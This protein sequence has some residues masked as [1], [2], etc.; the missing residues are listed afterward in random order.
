MNAATVLN[1]PEQ[2]L[3]NTPSAALILMIMT[4]R[5]EL[6]LVQTESR[7]TIAELQEKLA[8]RDAELE[9]L[10]KENINKTVNQPSSKQPEF[11]KNTGTTPDKKKTTRKRR[12]GRAGAGNR[13]KPKPD[14]VN[15]NPLLVC[16]ECQTDLTTQPVIETKKRIVEDIPPIPEKTI[17]SE[18]VQERKW[19]PTCGKVVASVS[20]AALPRSDIGL[21][22]LCLIAYL[23]VVSAISLPGI[24]AFLNSFFRLKVST[25]GLSRMMIRLANIMTTIHEEI[26]NDVKGGSIIHADETGW[27]VKG[28]L[29]WLWIFA[30]KRAAYYWPDPKRGSLVVAKILGDIFSGVLVTDAWCAYMKIVCSKQTCMAHILRKIRKFR[31]AYPDEYSIFSFHRKLKRILADGER[32][33]LGR[34]E[35]GEEIFIRR[36]NLLKKRLQQLLDWYNPGAILKEIIAKVARQQD[37]IL[38]FVE[39]DGVPTHNNYGEYIIKKGVLKRK[40]SGGSMSEEGFM[41]YAVIQSIAQTCH[42]RGLS[43]LGFLTASLIHY[44][45]TGKP[46]LLSQYEKKQYDDIHIQ[47][48]AA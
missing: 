43:F 23:W 22:S 26:L 9:K 10:T 38:T 8:Q 21:R 44:I 30:N 17:I 37:Y 24:A 20:E 1:F 42:L 14:V 5:A 12:K 19:C 39:H 27:R 15:A 4:L 18:E 2:D 36:L 28:K 25:A 35:L 13:V 48:E 3:L 6:E 29:W 31:D 45:R 11:D 32:L 46:L 40:V 7:K 33:Q 16:P 34:K 41:A 47:K